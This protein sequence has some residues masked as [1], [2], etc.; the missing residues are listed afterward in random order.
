M[1]PLYLGIENLP[2]APLG[3]PYGVPTQVFL[4]RTSNPA[5]PAAE[6]PG[7]GLKR[8]MTYLAD[9][10]GCGYYRCMAPDF[11]LNLYQKAVIV[12]STAMVLDPRFYQTVETIKFQRQATS[13]QRDF[14]KN[15]KVLAT[16]SNKKLIYEIDDVVFA[17]DIPLYN[18][19]RVAFASKEIQDCIKEIL[20]MMDEITVTCDYFKEYMIEKSGNKNVT[21]VPNYLA[22]GWFDRYYNLW[23]LQKRFEKNKKRP[24][25]AIFA[26]GTHVDVLNK[27]NQQ[28]DFAPVVQ[29]IYKTRKDFEW[30]FY[31][32]HP[33]PLKP[34]IDSGEIKFFPW[35]QLP[36]FAET[37]A[38]SGAQMTFASLQDNHFNRCKSNIKLIEAGALGLP[39]VCPDMVTYKDAFLK[40]KTG[41]EFIDLL[42]STLKNQTVYAEQ[43]KKARAYAEN[44]WLDDEKNLMKHYEAYFT[45]FG[46]KERKYLV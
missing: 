35:V 42:K 18:R 5:D 44:F 16:Q 22:K 21:V 27:V 45:P 9:Y 34:L 13:P 41:D 40:Y 29:H 14:I 23:D 46:S 30:H 17:E 11:L 43:C 32:S 37:M 7:A 36:D 3:I 10:G 25:I 4:N 19:N 26:S 33:L 28:D 12:E 31:G 24:I 1:T 39:C 15:L 8:A 2:G 38:K 6:I 20:S